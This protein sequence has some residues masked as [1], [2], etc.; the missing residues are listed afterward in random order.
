MGPGLGATQSGR[1]SDLASEDGGGTRAGGGTGE[2]QG[3]ASA[4]MLHEA[5]KDVIS[6]LCINNELSYEVRAAA[7]FAIGFPQ[8]TQAVF[9][10]VLILLCTHDLAR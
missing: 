10:A 5:S 1:G 8:Q 6:L 9:S 7:P 3:G 2:R 4:R